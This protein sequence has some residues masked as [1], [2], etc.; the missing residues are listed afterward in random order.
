LTVVIAYIL[1][2]TETGKE[3]EVLDH[4]KDVK[5][6]TESRMVYGEFDVFLRFEVGDLA[7]MDDIV[8]QIRRI[9]GVRQTTTLVGS[10]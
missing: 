3:Y 8:T 9:P 2:T 1:L 7:M 6:V 4:I 10:P 5:S